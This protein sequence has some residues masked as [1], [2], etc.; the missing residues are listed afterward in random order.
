VTRGEHIARAIGT[1]TLCHAE[2]L[3]GTVYADMG[4]V[5]LVA[6]PNLTRGRGGIGASLTDRDWVRAIRHGVRRDGTSL[7]VMPSEVFTFLNDSDLAALI[8]FLK[9]LPPVDRDVPR[10]RF[11]P[12]GR[13]LLATG[14]MNILVAPKTHEVERPVITPA[15]TAEYGRYLAS[16]SGCHGCH[17]FGLSGGRVAGPSNL[18][19]A[20][21]IT[22]AGIGQWSQEDFRRLMRTGVRPGGGRI[23]EF[24]PWR[25]LGRMTDDELHALWLYLRQAPPRPFGQK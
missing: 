24:M 7:I 11:G 22:T 17:G 5:G 19:P 23:N 14:R 6:G 12:V 18:P 15:P 13:A 2:D 20:S 9:Q 25:T 1:C 21:N 8:A 3:G 4:P 16:V 10:S